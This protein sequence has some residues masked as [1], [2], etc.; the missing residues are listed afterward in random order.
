MCKGV[1][2]QYFALNLMNELNWVEFAP[3]CHSSERITLKSLKS[4]TSMLT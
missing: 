2:L 3:V 4:L 1:Y